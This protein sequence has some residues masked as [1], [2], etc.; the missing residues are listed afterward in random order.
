MHRTSKPVRKCNGCGL[1]LGDRCGVYSNPRDQWSGR[2]HCPGYMNDKMLAEFEE[3]RKAT[4]TDLKRQD[5]KDCA[6]LRHTEGHHNGDRHVVA[7]A[8]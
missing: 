8:R 7:S 1:N 3:G 4:A 2:S 5:R 6:R